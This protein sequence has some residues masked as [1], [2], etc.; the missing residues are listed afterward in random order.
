[1]Q[2]MHLKVVALD[3]LQKGCFLATFSAPNSCP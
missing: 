2:E 1:M 3:T